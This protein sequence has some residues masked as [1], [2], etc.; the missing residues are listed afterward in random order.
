MDFDNAKNE[1][2]EIH[3]CHY[4]DDFVY[5]SIEAGAS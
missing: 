3:C 2:S 4:A 5:S 1:F